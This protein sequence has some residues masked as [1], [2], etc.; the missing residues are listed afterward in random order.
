MLTCALT[1]LLGACAAAPPKSLPASEQLWSR[2]ETEIG[3]ARCES[4]S[5]C[6]SAAVGDKPCGGP[7]R[8]L[9]WSTLRSNETRLNQLLAEHR[10]LRHAENLKSEMMSN[11]QFN[12]DPGARCIAQ[13]CTLLP[14]GLGRAPGRAD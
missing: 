8:Y 12:A 14:P 6:R 7:E 2:I 4:D 13:R 1:G 9:A 11:C 10:A 5:Q 3:D